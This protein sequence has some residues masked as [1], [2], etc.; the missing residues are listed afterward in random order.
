MTLTEGKVYIGKIKLNWIQRVASN[1]IVAAKFL[2]LGFVDVTS[3]GDGSIR[4]VQG[5]W[6][7]E[8]CNIDLP[9][10]VQDIREV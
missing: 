9:D 7:K 3:L 1:S 5:K 10:Q 6:N 8:T 2:D 4:Q